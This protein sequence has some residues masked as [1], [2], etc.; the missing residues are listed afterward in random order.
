MNSVSRPLLLLDRSL[1][2]RVF[3]TTNSVHLTTIGSSVRSGGG[4]RS[5]R[6]KGKD[7]KKKKRKEGKEQ[8]E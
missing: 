4:R 7:W 3:G 8:K 2:P 6:G 1:L 5:G